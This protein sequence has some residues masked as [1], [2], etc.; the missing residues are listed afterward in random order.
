[1]ITPTRG[2]MAQNGDDGDEED[3]EGRVADGGNGRG[4]KEFAHRLEL[5]DLRGKG[6]GRVGLGRQAHRHHLLEQA[7]GQ[8]VVQR[9]SGGLQQVRT[10]GAQQQL[11]QNGDHNPRGQHPQG[12]KIG[13]RHHPVIDLHDKQRRGD[14]Q[15]VGKDGRRSDLDKGGP[16][17]GHRRFQPVTF[18]GPGIALGAA[19]AIIDGAGKHHLARIGRPQFLH[20]DFLRPAMGEGAERVHRPAAAAR[21]APTGPPDA[22]HGEPDPAADGHYPAAD[23]PPAWPPRR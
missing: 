19:I 22:W 16:R 7:R 21:P 6:T 11:G 15:K 10:Q 4:G 17:L 5:F 13:G 1:M 23:R 2:A 3:D 12:R 18:L 9:L 8:L 20:G 14:R